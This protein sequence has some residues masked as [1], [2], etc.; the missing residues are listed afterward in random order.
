M[1]GDP[2]PVKPGPAAPHSGEHAFAVPETEQSSDPA[3]K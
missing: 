2:P 1:A 3:A